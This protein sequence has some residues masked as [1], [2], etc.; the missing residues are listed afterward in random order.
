MLPKKDSQLQAA[1]LRG[2]FP[3]ILS[4]PSGS[5]KTT[6]LI[7][8]L[9]RLNRH[10]KFVDISLGIRRSLNSNLI[11]HTYIYSHADLL[12][13]HHTHNLIIETTI[14]MPSS[15]QTIN[16]SPPS[17]S[18]HFY[19]FIGRI[20]Y[21]KLSISDLNIIE[22]SILVDVQTTSIQQPSKE[23][24]TM[25]KQHLVSTK[26]NGKHSHSSSRK[27]RSTL[28]IDT[29]ETS[30]LDEIDQIFQFDDSEDSLHTHYQDFK[31]C[32]AFDTSKVIRYLYENMLHFLDLNSL[33][34]SYECLSAGIDLSFI[35]AV[36]TT[37]SSKSSQRPFRPVSNDALPHL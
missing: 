26:H 9:H 3:I 32:T 21:R 31:L 27:Q 30:S 5:G 4:G 29:S 36:L 14:Q 7:R 25:Q 20:F 17:K 2:I 23:R 24:S 10:S 19:R 16:F 8:V 35:H 6:T 18:L 34:A 12:N 11:L 15:P 37:T 13:I 28:L 1:I 22:N 33:S